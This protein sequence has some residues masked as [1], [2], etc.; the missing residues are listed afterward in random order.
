LRTPGAD[1]LVGVAVF[2]VKVD[3][4]RF[5]GLLRQHMMGDLGARPDP[6]VGIAGRRA[7]IFS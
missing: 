3:R 5:S 4:H 1:F 7:T 6:D 2:G